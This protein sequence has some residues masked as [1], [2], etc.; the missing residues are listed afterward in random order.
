MRCFPIAFSICAAAAIVTVAAQQP[1]AQPYDLVL[2][3][4]RVLDGT[5][6]PAVNADVGI[7]GARIAA[8][9]SLTGAAAARTIDVRGLTVSPGF[10]DPHSHSGGGLAGALN[11]AQPLLAQ[12]IT[13]VVINPDGGGSVDI[14]AQRARL[15]ERQ[16]GVNVALFVPHGSIRQ[17]VLG[18]SDRDPTPAEVEQMVALV[19]SGM[20]A[21]GIGLSSGLYYAP[22]SYSKTEEVIAMARAAGEAGGVY[23]SHIRDEGDYNVGV[24]AS[25]DEVIRIAEEGK[26]P[27]IVTHMKALGKGNWGLSQTITAHIEAARKRG[28]DVWADQYPYEA[29][30]TSITGALIPRWAQVG[31]GEALQKRITGPERAR[32]IGEVKANIERR[33]G[34]NTLVIS[35]FAADKELEGRSLEF[36]AA[37]RKKSAEEVALDLLSEGGAGLISFNMTENDIE[38]I[39]RQPYTM[40]STD[41][42]LVPMGQGK[43]HPRA[44]GTFPRKLRIYVRERKVMDLPAA[45]RSMTSL[46]AAVFGMKDRGVLREGAWADIVVFDPAKIADKATYQEPHQLSEGIVYALVNGELVRD[47]N[48]FTNKL[49]G[50][51]VTSERK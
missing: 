45:I 44:Y 2:R 21:G 36:I 10:I 8:I 15:E 5:G 22:G 14:A 4:G 13:T 49:P 51:I 39:M 31:G 3:G 1:A 47:T 16:T 24:V 43:P 18:M 32:L 11:H 12:G 46:T 35:R 26:L 42:D 50:R 25:V 30:G 7:R 20:S 38:H 9:G 41:G 28:V 40:T 6:S 33:G 29:S 17:R 23:S 27:G 34:A 48:Q 37:A 19:R